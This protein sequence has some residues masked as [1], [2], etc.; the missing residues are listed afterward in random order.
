MPL[1]RSRVD[2]ARLNRIQNAKG[3][4]GMP[5]IVNIYEGEPGKSPLVWSNADIAWLAKSVFQNNG[6]NAFKRMFD[7][8]CFDCKKQGDVRSFEQVF[9]HGWNCSCG[10]KYEPLPHP[11]DEEQLSRLLAQN[12]WKENKDIPDWLR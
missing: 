7:V 4:V 5:G 9:I 8:V 10:R 6:N 3:G 11:K 1:D 2:L 12:N